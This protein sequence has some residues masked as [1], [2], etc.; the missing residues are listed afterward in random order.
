MVGRTGSRHGAIWMLALV[1]LVVSACG[2]ESSPTTQAPQPEVVENSASS[3]STATTQVPG[4]DQPAIWPAGDVVFS[5]PQEAAEDFVAAVLISD[6]EPL[7]GEFQQG[8]ARSGEIAV[9]FAGED[10]SLDPPLERGLLLLRQI[11]PTDGWFVIGAVSDG[12]SIADPPTPATVSAGPVTVAG[13]GRG[14]EGTLVVSA[15]SPGDSNAMLD[16]QIAAGGAMADLEP[17]SV[18]LDLTGSEPGD[19][20]AILV[21]GDAGLGDDPSTFA[22]V[23]VVVD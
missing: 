18:E 15:F 3:E 13:E 4:L 12:A 10:G 14:F 11:G 22:A 8:D 7:L 19:V 23:P 20:I 5:T 1:G 21:Q 9:L 6:G 17:Y 16:Q 2:D